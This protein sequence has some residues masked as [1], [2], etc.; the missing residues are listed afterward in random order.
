MDVRMLSLSARRRAAS[1]R[2]EP[3]AA[4]SPSLKESLEA[5]DVMAIKKILRACDWLVRSA[6]PRDLSQLRRCHDLPTL[7]CSARLLTKKR[8]NVPRDVHGR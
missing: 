8:P 5:L 7:P 1:P 3:L 6:R 4:P 2:E